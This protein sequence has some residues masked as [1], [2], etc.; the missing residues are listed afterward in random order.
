MTEAE[1]LVRSTTRAIASTV[2]EVAAL[3]LEPT[4]DELPSSARRLRRPRRQPAAGRPGRWRPWLAPAAAALAVLAV[5]SALVIVK[6]IPNG[7]LPPPAANATPATATGVPRYYVA[8]MQADQPYLLVGDTATGATVATVRSPSGVSLDS[9]YGTAVN[10]QTFIVTG[11]RARGASAGTQWY[12]LRI[13]SGAVTS[14]R[15]TPLPI[16]VRQ[17][18]AGVALSPDGTKLA[19]AL[20]GP[21][22]VLRIYSVASGALLRA[23]S[24]P[25]GQIEAV[26]G[27][28]SSWQY[29]AMALRWFPNGR[30]L[31]FAWN[32]TAIRALDATAPNGNL[33]ARGAVLAAIGTSYTPEGTSVTCDASHGWNL[34]LGAQGWAVICAAT[35][36]E[37]PT[38]SA[39]VRGPAGNG[40]CA[41][42]YPVTFGIDL[43]SPYGADGGENRQLGQ[44]ALATECSGQVQAADG[45]YLGWSNADG[46][47]MIGSLVSN[48][49]PRFGIF[50]GGR[51]T[52][53][54]P[55]PTS[56]VAPIGPLFGADAW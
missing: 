51:F 12:L 19:V 39:S 14:A 49:H 54:S 48:G 45:L 9:A 23:W 34:I 42:S 30:T 53:L 11:E 28:P 38:S 32:A 46:T 7:H 25:A 5:V 40:K 27:Y 47:V 43:Q 50:R 26:K 2:R 44:L 20:A 36:K 29:N 6:D 35:W 24:A 22:A 3:R 1:E 17:T 4:L 10:D 13:T 41:G 52:T 37:P 16:P 18:P 55:L 31:A 33:L 15:L 8:W 21:P 56:M